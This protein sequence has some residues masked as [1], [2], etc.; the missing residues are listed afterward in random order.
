MPSKE[1]MKKAR[2]HSDYIWNVL[3]G[4]KPNKIVQETLRQYIA[5]VIDST[6]EEQIDI[7]SNISWNLKSHSYEVGKRKKAYVQHCYYEDVS[8]AINSQKE[9]N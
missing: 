7:D 1:S 8:L 6:K 3:I 2:E 5:K 9:K 4:A